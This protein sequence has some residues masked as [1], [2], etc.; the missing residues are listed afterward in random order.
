MSTSAEPAVTTQQAQQPP[1][2]HGPAIA[3]MYARW[4]LDCV[5]QSAVAVASDYVKRYRQYSRVPGG[6]AKALAD[7]RIRTGSDPSFPSADQRAAIFSPLLG[8]SDAKG[9]TSK[10]SFQNLAS[11]VRAA[12]IAYS[13][14]AVDSGEPMLR[15]AFVDAARN[16]KVC[17]ASLSGGVVDLGESETANIFETSVTILS[18]IAVAVAFGLPPAPAFPW[19][20]DGQ[21][22]GDGAYLIEAIT[23]TLQPSTVG[24]MPQGQFL[25]LQ[26]VAASGAKLISHLVQSDPE[27]DPEQL[28]T[29]AYSWAMAL[30][31]LAQNS[32]AANPANQAA[33]AS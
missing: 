14:R 29:E 15:Q 20:V 22:D 26:Q 8:G 24:T 25:T 4:T 19:P 5:I 9:P 6:T 16:F 18:D 30:A 27:E 32:S 13:E 28:I 11:A 21:L 1:T 2:V 17:L 12:A 23:Q 3:R 33:A 7:L 10:T 31:R